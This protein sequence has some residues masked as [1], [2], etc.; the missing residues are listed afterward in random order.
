MSYTIQNGLLAIVAESPFWWNFHTQ[1]PRSVPERRSVAIF[2]LEARQSTDKLGSTR[3]SR[4]VDSLFRFSYQLSVRLGCIAIR[5]CL[6]L[7]VYVSSDHPSSGHWDARV[8]LI[9]FRVLSNSSSAA[10]SV[11][12]F[13]QSFLL[14]A[15]ST[16]Q[17]RAL[18]KY[19][20]FITS[21]RLFFSCWGTW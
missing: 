13:S 21:F 7:F 18:T 6:C 16:S 1:N 14:T 2:S 9:D 5:I 3:F 20:S 12:Y 4:S 11:H 15:S 19:L 8:S 17:L 10:A